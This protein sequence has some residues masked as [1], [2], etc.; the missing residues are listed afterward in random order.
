MSKANPGDGLPTYQTYDV[1]FKW[2]K[3]TK[4]KGSCDTKHM[5]YLLQLAL[6]KIRVD[7][8]KRNGYFQSIARADKYIEHLDAP[9]IIEY[10]INWHN[11]DTEKNKFD[12]E[13]FDKSYGEDMI[14]VLKEIGYLDFLNVCDRF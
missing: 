5:L 10:I 3:N 11:Q 2:D 9:K 8:I 7:T 4:T 13:L 12:G 6:D 14:S 1:A